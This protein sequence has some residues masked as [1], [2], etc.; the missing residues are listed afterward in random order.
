MS[1]NS[2]NFGS[3]LSARGR[4][5]DALATR[6]LNVMAERRTMSGGTHRATHLRELFDSAVE[7]DGEHLAQLVREILRLGVPS[8]IVT[9]IYIPE[10]ARR[11][12]AA[13]LA[14]RLSFVEVTIGTARLQA[15]AR[16][17]AST[18][19]RCRGAH[20]RVCVIVP[21]NED[22]TLGAVILSGQLRRL[23]IAVS[24]HAGESSCEVARALQRDQPDAVMISASHVDCVDE[25]A[26]LVV[27]SRRVANRDMP[28]TVGGPL[29]DLE[30][31][32][33]A[34]TRADHAVCD[35]AQALTLCGLA[36]ARAQPARR[37]RA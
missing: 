29:L 21:R 20:S 4:N 30:I 2:S 3:G 11:L 9:D 35:A 14:D 23:G 33:L 31:D 10:V 25:V 37:E 8:E 27:A 6:A 26:S 5:V 16:D 12:G 18:P 22:H 7:P 19:D 34:E 36:P 15:I 17:L 24:M 1:E 13:W 28:I 32:I